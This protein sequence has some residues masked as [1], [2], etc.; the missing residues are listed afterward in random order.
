MIISARILESPALSNRFSSWWTV[1]ILATLYSLSFVD[2]MILVLLAEDIK[3]SFHISD[4]QIGLLLGAGFS[5][6]YALAGIPLAGLVDRGNRRNVVAVGVVVWSCL[7]A[8]S[9]FASNFL[10]LFVLRC[11]VAL[12]EAVLTPAA[13]SIIADLF[14]SERRT[15]PTAI[16]GAMSSIMAIGS[17]LIGALVLAAINPMETITGIPAWRLTLI[18]LGLTGIVIALIFVISV[19][20]P[21]RDDEYHAS[22]GYIMSYIEMWRY[23]K[24]NRRLYA[25][26][27]SGLMLIILV[28][29]GALTWIP[30]I[31]VRRFGLSTEAVGYT[32]GSVGAIAGLTS[33][34]FWSILIT[35]MTR[36]G[37]RGGA[38][39]GLVVSSAVSVIFLVIS[40]IQDTLISSMYMMFIALVGVTSTGILAPLAL[41]E[42]GSSEYR[43]RLIALY[44]LSSYLISY[45][46]GP[47]LVVG[48]SDIFAATEGSLEIGIIITAVMFGPLACLSFFG[49]TL[50]C[51]KVKFD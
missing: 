51:R 20:E 32:L 47:L 49:A 10:T 1:T 33:A 45:T 8:A 3:V 9:G 44:L 4:Y 38:V 35:W 22:G 13:I 5:I 24:D 26:F 30:T 48:F 15:L 34:I 25:L 17:L 21:T 12:G 7:T 36:R 43:G 40:L 39:F 31:M 6:I 18:T 27:Y 50:S 2:R 46:V 11:G 16:Y 41:Q 29:L 14:S 28:Q 37:L 19:K 23:L 42:F